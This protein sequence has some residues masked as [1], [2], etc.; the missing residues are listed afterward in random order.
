MMQSIQQQFAV[1]RLQ[2]LAQSGMESIAVRWGLLLIACIFFWAGVIV[3]YGE[4]RDGYVQG[5]HI[6]SEKLVR[7]QALESSS[8]RWE[9]AMSE[10]AAASSS[11]P[12]L[13]FDASSSAAAQAALLQLMRALIAQHHLQ[14][15]GQSFIDGDVEPGIGNRVGVSF[16]LS[17]SLAHIVALL[18]GVAQ[19]HKMIVIDKLFIGRSGMA[20]YSVQLQVSGFWSSG[21]A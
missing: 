13:L 2:L 7:L 14:L 16:R 15:Q 6:K 11:L 19:H 17:G 10:Y 20:E 18:D 5:M 21:N 3:P 12:T 4:W 8:L 9:K 1:L